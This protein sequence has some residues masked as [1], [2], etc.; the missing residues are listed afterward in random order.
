[1]DEAEAGARGFG[2]KPRPQA[3][4]AG[5]LTAVSA[6]SPP[7]PVSPRYIDSG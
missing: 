2:T 7:N 4:W 5:A 3:T 6:L 1:M